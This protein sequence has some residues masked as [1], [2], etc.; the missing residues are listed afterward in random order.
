MPHWSVTP[1][2]VFLWG[3]AGE[4]GA[5]TIAEMSALFGYWPSL[6]RDL[7]GSSLS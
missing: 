3:V 2:R 4:N 5:G 7:D 6:F 1:R